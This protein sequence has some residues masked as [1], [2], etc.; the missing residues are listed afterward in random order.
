MRCRPSSYIIY[1]E[2]FEVKNIMKLTGIA[3][4]ILLFGLAIFTEAQYQTK[5]YRPGGANGGDSL[6]VENGG[7]ITVFAG[8]KIDMLTGG[9]IYMR[10]P[11]AIDSLAVVKSPTSDV[12]D[13]CLVFYIS[14]GEP[15][16][17]FRASDDDAAEITTNTSDQM[18]FQNASGG[19]KFTQGDIIANLMDIIAANDTIHIKM[20]PTSD[21]TDSTLILTIASGEPIIAFRASDDD[22]SE[23]TTNTSDQ[24]LFQ[25]ASGGYKFTQ[26]DVIANSID[27]I[28][29][30]DTI[31]IKMSPTSD[32]TDSTLIFTLS[33]GNP[34]IAFKATD[35]DASEITV[36][37]DDQ[38]LFQNAS[39]GYKFSGGNVIPDG[40]DIESSKTVTI[41]SG[42]TLD[43]QS[44]S[45]INL[46]G[47]K[48]VTTLYTGTPGADSV[49]IP[50][51]DMDSD[52]IVFT[53]LHH[54]STGTVYTYFSIPR[55]GN[56]A[57]YFNANPSIEIKVSVL[58]LED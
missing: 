52:D 35:G 7:Q 34:L 13:S 24:M 43:A 50:V 15:I 45:T 26:G 16:I 47:K 28:A 5:I 29:A 31:H 8:G 30:G 18:L 6:D 25:N 36:N 39:G 22:A 46:G 51:P 40:I 42:G 12:T 38:M 54:S 55:T 56:V 2:G 21:P 44:G 48:L 19:Y 53:E 10:L 32:P 37:T 41:K 33:S 23:I 27:V 49:L 3:I 14:S 58:A 1:M 20:S 9:K 17:A 11:K 4:L 57:V